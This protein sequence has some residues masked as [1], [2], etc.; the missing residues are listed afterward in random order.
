[1]KLGFFFP[2]P[3]FPPLPRFFFKDSEADKMPGPSSHS[4][5]GES[6]RQRRNRRGGSRGPTPIIGFFH[7]KDAVVHQPDYSRAARVVERDDGR[8]YAERLDLG[9]LLR[10]AKAWRRAS[11]L[12]GGIWRANN[13]LC[14]GAWI[15]RSALRFQAV[16]RQGV[17]IWPRTSPTSPP[18]PSRSKKRALETQLADILGAATGMRLGAQAASQIGRARDQ[19]LTFCDLSRR[20]RGHQTTV[21]SKRCGPV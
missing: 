12:F 6:R 5:S 8:P 4:P 19:L 2:N 7:C 20:G 17:P 3:P 9:S 15:G 1:L 13:G 11:N 14:I 21:R 10:A 16:V 18:R